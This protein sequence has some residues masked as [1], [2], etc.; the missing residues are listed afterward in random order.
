MEMLPFCGYFILNWNLK[1][2]GYHNGKNKRVEVYDKEPLWFWFSIV[3]LCQNGINL[4]ACG[5]FFF[6]Q[7]LCVYGVE[8]AS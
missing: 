5:L 3:V 1:I 2:S 4:F 8:I 7:Q 6:L